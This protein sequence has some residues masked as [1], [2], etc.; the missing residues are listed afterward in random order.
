VLSRTLNFT[1][2]KQKVKQPQEDTEDTPLTQTLA[3][4]SIES[5]VSAIMELWKMQHS[6]EQ[7]INV[8]VRSFA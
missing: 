7:N 3:A 8:P 2:M 1:K 4:S 5:Y 6:L